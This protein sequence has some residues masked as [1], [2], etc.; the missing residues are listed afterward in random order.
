[1]AVD[2]E[3]TLLTTEQCLLHPNRNPDLS[4][5]EIEQ[6][7][8]DFLGVEHVVWLGQGLAEDRDTDGHVDLI[9][10]HARR[11]GAPASTPPGTPS[12]E[13]MADNRSRLVAAGLEVIDFRSCR[14]SRSAART[15][16]WAT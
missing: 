12:S 1:M 16:P 11:R 4:R 13:R 10:A 3:G 8:G 7:L 15:S 14:R 2:G 6:G 5:E 9:A